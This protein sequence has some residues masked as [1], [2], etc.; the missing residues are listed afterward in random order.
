MVI[1]I[2]AKGHRALLARSREHVQ[3]VHVVVRGGDA[4]AVVSAGDEE[5][6]AVAHG[7]RG[8]DAP[9]LRVRPV[10]TEAEGARDAEVVDLLQDRLPLALL[11]VLVGRIGGP[12]AGRGDQLD[13]D[14]AA[15]EAFGRQKFETWRVAEPAPRTSTGTFSAG[16]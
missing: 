6:V 14:E 3:V 5:H 1:G 15:R 4:G 11:V 7:H 8:V 10:E 2:V 12:V 9:V 13:R 16:P